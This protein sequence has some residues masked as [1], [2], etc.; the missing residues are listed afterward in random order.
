[1]AKSLV[2]LLASLL[3]CSGI[4]DVQMGMSQHFDHPNPA[5]E[6]EFSYHDKAM[7]NK[8]FIFCRACKTILR[9]VIQFVGKTVSKEEINRQLDRICGKIRIRGCKSFLQKYKNK[10]VIY[11]LSG[12]KAGTICIKLKLCK[13]MDMQ[14]I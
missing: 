9:K 5:R 12:D 8:Q 1:M 2:F 7:E 14:T 6:M 10:L 4:S 13:Q 11:L 3:F